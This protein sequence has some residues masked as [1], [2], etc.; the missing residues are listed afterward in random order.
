MPQFGFFVTFFTMPSK[1]SSKEQSFSHNYFELR[2]SKPIHLSPDVDDGDLL[3]SEEAERGLDVLDGVESH[4]AALPG[5]RREKGREIQKLHFGDL[6]FFCGK[7]RNFEHF[8]LM[9][10]IESE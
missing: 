5:L 9:R 3:V 7:R 8:L 6:S 10:E 1:K 2:N 4:P